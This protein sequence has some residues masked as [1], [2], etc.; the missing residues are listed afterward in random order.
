MA[1]WEYWNKVFVTDNIF[2]EQELVDCDTGSSGCDGGNGQ[3]AFDY[4]YSFGISSES[5]YKYVAM[6]QT[7]MRS[8]S[9]DL[10]H[11][12]RPC[13]AAINGDQVLLTEFIAENGPAFTSF[14]LMRISEFV[15]FET[16]SIFRCKHR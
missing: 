3:S 12:G 7:C 5:D 6:D 13:A 11:Q 4:G 10:R 15:L 9:E 2:S 16:L 14:G 8:Q 1:V